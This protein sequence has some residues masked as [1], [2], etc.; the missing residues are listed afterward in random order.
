MKWPIVKFGYH[1]GCLIFEQDENKQKKTYVFGFL[2]PNNYMANLGYFIL[3]QKHLISEEY[4]ILNHN[5]V[6]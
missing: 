2:T 5:I 3:K 1:I 4:G 6:S